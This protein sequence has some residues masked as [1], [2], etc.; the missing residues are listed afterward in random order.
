MKPV[1]FLVFNRPDCTRR[2]FEAI[3][4]AR[5]EKLYVIADGPRESRQGEK[6]KCALVRKI[7]DDGVDWPC[8]VFRNYSSENL[9][10]GARVSSGLDWAFSKCDK[11]IVVED[12][13]LPDQ[14]F[15]WLCDELLDR[16]E[17]DQRVGQISAS[18]FICNQIDSPY[19]YIFSRYG[20]IWGWA[21]WSR[22]W[23]HYSFVMDSWAEI[24]ESGDFR[25]FIPFGM[26]RRFKRPVYDQLRNRE[27]DTWDLQWG[28]AKMS[29]S[30]L[31]AV[32]TCNLIE[33]LGFSAEATH[34]FDPSQNILRPGRLELPLKH[35]PRVLAD[36]DFV[37]EFSISC[38]PAG[39]KRKFARFLQRFD[40][41]LAREKFT[42]R[43][44]H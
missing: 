21:S 4:A 44:S 25:T 37:E 28:Y 27:I 2:T 31:S 38:V 33:N 40:R 34:T 23:K 5:P 13:V 43:K 36:A 30:M 10:C 22:A 14:S 1:A 12:D 18:P 9:G 19:S 42:S 20:S 11:L 29:N 26:E 7:I 6:E 16:Y 8:D 24:R 32:S 41:F 17:N 35:P 15:F 39:W 3:R